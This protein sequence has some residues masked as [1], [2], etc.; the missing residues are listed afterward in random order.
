MTEFAYYWLH[1]STTTTKV[2][3]VSCPSRRKFLELLN[4]WNRQGAGIWQFW[5][6][7]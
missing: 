5:A 1:I 3:T 6:E 4:T 2:R 7:G